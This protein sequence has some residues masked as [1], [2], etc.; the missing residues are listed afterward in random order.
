[1]MRRNAKSFEVNTRFGRIA[2]RG[3]FVMVALFATLIG[4][5]KGDSTA[6]ENACSGGQALRADYFDGL[7]LPKKTLA[8][9]FD[10]GP[11]VRTA[12]LSTYLKQQGIRAGFFV[13]GFHAVPDS[14]DFKRALKQVA[15][16]GHLVANHT[17]NHVSLTGST[18]FVPPVPR[19]PANTVVQEVE[20]TDKLIE[21]Y[22]KDN[23]WL[24]R[25]PFGHFDSQTLT[26]LDATP[27]K[28]YIGPIKWDIGD[29]MGVDHAAD[30]ACW[31]TDGTPTWKATPVKECGD[32]YLTEIR[33]LGNGIVL[34]HDPYFTDN[35]P[36]KGGTVDM[37]KYIVPILK[38]E[39]YKFVRIDEVPEIA[40]AFPKAGQPGGP[41]GPGP[42]GTGE[43]GDPN[44]PP[45]GTP[46][47][48]CP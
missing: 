23:H 21:P 32:L 4:C 15:D 29:S 9:T 13:N 39:G 1:M 35:D 19:P 16:D 38:Q 24:F 25:P 7:S 8:L 47:G 18:D 26:T 44:A 40:D 11:G 46:G 12:E 5:K 6:D 33:K 2:V 36:A 28:K 41:G 3:G 45:A 31:N 20:L 22:V 14:H 34:M 37:I 30:W 48:P 17:Q 27:M 10:D 43:P 42:S